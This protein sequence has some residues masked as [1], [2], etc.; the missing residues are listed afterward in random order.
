M[1]RKE[2]RGLKKNISIKNQSFLIWKQNHIYIFVIIYINIK[3]LNVQGRWI[4]N[5]ILALM[6]NGVLEIYM[7]KCIHM[8]MAI[9]CV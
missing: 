4:D 6:I 7:H 2:W 9:M 8:Y 1:A 5:M 3:T